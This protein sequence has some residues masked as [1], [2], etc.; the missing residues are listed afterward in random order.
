MKLKALLILLHG[1]A[2][3]GGQWAPY[4][5]L[6]GDV[7]DVVAPDLPGHGAR[8]AQ[9]FTLAAAVQLVHDIVATAGGRPVVLVGHSLGGYIAMAYAEQHPQA[10]AGLSPIGAAA[11]PKGLGALVYQQLAR[12]YGAVGDERM[13]RLTG[14][15]FRRLIDPRVAQALQARGLNYAPLQAAWSE[16]VA[17]CSARQLRHVAC[18]V[19]ILGGQWDQ[20]HVHARRFAAAAPH[21]QVVTGARRHHLWPMSHP[22]E[23]AAHLKTWLQTLPALQTAP[24]AAPPTHSRKIET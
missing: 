13:A 22:E 1:T 4:P 14:W 18:P 12:L 19:L 15:S 9:P 16:V 10:L 5:A 6:L 3:N 8:S 17:H 11:E 23:V 2:M 21:G 7:A 20:L 24:D